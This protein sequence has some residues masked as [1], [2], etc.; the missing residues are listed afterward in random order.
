[1]FRE[2]NN[3][4]NDRSPFSLDAIL[5]IIHEYFQP[6][7]GRK[8]KIFS[9]GRKNNIRILKKVLVLITR[10]TRRFTLHF[11]VAFPF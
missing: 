4:K 9:L 10:I 7:I 11:A 3:N 2:K 1:M 5:R 8:I 6:K